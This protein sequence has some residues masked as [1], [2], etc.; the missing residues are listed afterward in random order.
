MGKERRDKQWDPQHKQAISDA[1]RRL[2]QYDKTSEGSSQV[3]LLV[4]CKSKL[5]P[6]G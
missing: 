4:I 1:M 6:Q 5:K 2:E 3:G